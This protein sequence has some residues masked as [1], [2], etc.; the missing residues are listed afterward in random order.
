M[1]LIERMTEKAIDLN[2][3]VCRKQLEKP[4]TGRCGHNYCTRC[5]ETVLNLQQKKQSIEQ[6]ECSGPQSLG[7]FKFECPVKDCEVTSVIPNATVESFSI[8][9]KI[10]RQLEALQ[11][12]NK[13]I[14]CIEHGK[15][16][17]F[18]CLNCK[19]VLCNRCRSEHRLHDFKEIEEV[20]QIYAK[21][22]KGLLEE[23]KKQWEAAQADQLKIQ[24]YE[25]GSEKKTE[26]NLEK[27]LE[28]FE[29]S[30]KMLKEP[31]AEVF[32][33]VLKDFQLL[34][35]KT[36]K[37]R[38]AEIQWALSFV[39]EFIR[40]ILESPSQNALELVAFH[41]L[42]SEYLKTIGA[43]QKEVEAPRTNQ[44]AAAEYKK[45]YLELLERKIKDRI[46]LLFEGNS[47]S[48][49]PLFFKC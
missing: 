6:V 47:I 48:V 18:L 9:E 21:L 4:R 44:R 17:Q 38:T 29:L 25:K 40:P 43:M 31:Q 8:N 7:K 16:C 39:H 26:E 3:A 5:L 49:N 14:I 27:L 15:E 46:I 35:Y 19:I 10:N 28:E 33:K 2:C 11:A 13:K 23:C 20:I 34:Q 36:G 42:M 30:E 12:K 32:A 45:I 22:C 37:K 1:N 24:E 41:E